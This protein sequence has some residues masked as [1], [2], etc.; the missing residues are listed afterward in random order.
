MRCLVVPSFAVLLPIGIL[1]SAGL[2]IFFPLTMNV[3]L[4]CVPRG[5]LGLFLSLVAVRITLGP[6]F[7]LVISGL[8]CTL[9][10]WRAIFV[11]PLAGGLV[12]SLAYA[13]RERRR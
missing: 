3:V 6:A 9:F 10:G 2:G 8:M 11:V 1:Q 7:G 4:A 5:R 12:L 13:I